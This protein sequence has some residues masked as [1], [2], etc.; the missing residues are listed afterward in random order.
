MS[1]TMSRS[2]VAEVP[3]A[4]P[5]TALSHFERLLEFETDYWDVHASLSSGA[6]DFVVLDVRSPELYGEGHVVGAV[7]LPHRLMTDRNLDE[8]PAETHVVVD[9]AAPHCTA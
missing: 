5:S 9:C 6:R 2:L 1:N 3:A 4:H 8:Y 7:N